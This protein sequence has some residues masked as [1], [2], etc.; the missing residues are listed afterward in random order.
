LNL[1]KKTYDREIETL[2]AQTIKLQ[3]QV[4]FNHTAGVTVSPSKSSHHHMAPPAINTKA[5]S[6]ADSHNGLITPQG[7]A[8]KSSHGSG[9][10]P[11]VL[12]NGNGTGADAV[13]ATNSLSP[14]LKSNS[15]SAPL[16]M[17]TEDGT[18]TAAVT[19]QSSSST[20]TVHSTRA[21]MGPPTAVTSKVSRLQGTVDG[22][23]TKTRLSNSSSIPTRPRSSSN[24][25]SAVKSTTA[26]NSGDLSASASGANLFSSAEKSS[27]GSGNNST[28]SSAML[29]S[30]HA[31]PVSTNSKIPALSARSEEALKRHQARM[32]KKREALA[33][34]KTKKDLLI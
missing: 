2:K 32:D 1:M 22:S 5:H 29:L 10:S 23:G 14:M 15:V 9:S 16:M 12:N 26:T 27:Q 34:D 19:K 17:S 25:R 18:T 3:S 11:A 30:S 28:H 20:S 6:T 33:A 13:K 24:T 21:T 4:A 31:V 7:S 8:V